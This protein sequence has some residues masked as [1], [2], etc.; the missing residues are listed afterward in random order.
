MSTRVSMSIGFLNNVGAD[1]SSI[2]F[3]SSSELLEANV[4]TFSQINWS[5]DCSSHSK[6][7][8]RRNGHSDG[9]SHRRCCHICLEYPTFFMLSLVF[10]TYF[11]GKDISYI[12]AKIELEHLGRREKT[13][14]SNLCSLQDFF[15]GI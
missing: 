6:G 1:V 4:R 2:F 7:V 5:Q 15:Y 3:K 9:F 11:W 10:I 12:F 13:T 14:R 8:G